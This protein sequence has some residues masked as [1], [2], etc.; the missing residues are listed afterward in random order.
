M[1][2]FRRNIMLS[3]S[4]ISNEINGG[5]VP[6]NLEYSSGPNE[7]NAKI[8]QYLKSLTVD[9]NIDFGEDGNFISFEYGTIRFTLSGLYII[10]LNED[11][12]FPEPNIEW[13]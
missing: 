11:G 7:N 2:N 8:Y 9:D 6:T 3:N 10:T 5:G 12:S 1:D 4:L 13:N